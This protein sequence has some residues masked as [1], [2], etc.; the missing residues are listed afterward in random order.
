[1][2]YWEVSEYEIL[3]KKGAHFLSTPYSMNRLFSE[4]FR[5]FGGVFLEVCETISGGS[6][7]V[8]RGNIQEIYPETN[9][10][11]NQKIPIRYYNILFNIA[12]NS[13]FNEWGV[14]KFLIILF[15]SIVPFLV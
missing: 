9:Q 11:K 8:F 6:G 13:L 3:Q 12:L 2:P 4:L 5:K 14:L 1:M 10:E 7:E 15:C